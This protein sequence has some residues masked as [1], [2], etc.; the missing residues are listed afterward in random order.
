MHVGAQP[1]KRWMTKAFLKAAFQ[2]PFEQ[3]GCSRVSGYVEWHNEAARK[4]D[5]HLGFTPEAILKGASSTG[6]DVVLYVMR[7]GN[8]RYVDSK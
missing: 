2:Y 4:F 6:G 7:K 8:C 5:E 1:G 3:L